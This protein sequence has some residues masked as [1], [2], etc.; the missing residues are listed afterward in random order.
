MSLGQEYRRYLVKDFKLPIEFF[1]DFHW[2]YAKKQGYC[3][4]SSSGTMTHLEG[5]MQEVI[6]GEKLSNSEGFYAY[7]ASVRDVIIKHISSKPEYDALN[8]MKLPA[9]EHTEKKQLYQANNNNQVFVSLDLIKANF[10][11]L[12]HYDSALV[13]NLTY[14]KFIKQFTPYDY[15]VES[16]Q[17]RQVIFGNLNP[18]RQQYLQKMIMSQLITKVRENDSLANV[19]MEI[20]ASS[21]DEVVFKLMP[22]VD[23]NAVVVEIKTMLS[24]TEFEDMIKVSC[25]ILR[26]KHFK[27]DS[28][29]VHEFY[30][31]EDYFTQQVEIKSV[32]GCYYPQVYKL[33]HDLPIF[34]PE[35]EFF[36]M[37]SK[38]MFQNELELID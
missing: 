2:D 8:N 17:L 36:Y 33:V 38:C 18:K 11:C 29:K 23:V 35:M 14:N 31:K 1:D 7:S 10:N 34:K 20:S 16:K 12:K 24:Q 15:F 30:L 4:D 28:S 32:S 21:S 19:I 13:D 37:E 5:L 6:D 27:A 26:V 9:Y 22:N 3:N 25:F